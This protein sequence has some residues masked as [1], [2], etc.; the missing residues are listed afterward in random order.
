MDERP[1]A[2]TSMASS[3][4]SVDSDIVGADVILPR[5]E[6]LTELIHPAH[7]NTHGI[8]GGLFLARR[9]NKSVTDVS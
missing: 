4:Q 8:S 3:G 7:F 6:H 1:L 2:P 9:H 5:L